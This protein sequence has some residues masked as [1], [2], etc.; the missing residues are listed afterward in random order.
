[1]KLDEEYTCLHLKQ[2]LL[3]VTKVY[4]KKQAVLTDG[5]GRGWLAHHRE[6]EEPHL[7]LAHVPKTHTLLTKKENVIKW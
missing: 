6:F 2:E 1:M 3:K 4:S 5:T 7:S